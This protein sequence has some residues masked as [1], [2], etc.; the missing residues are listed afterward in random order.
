MLLFML[1]IHPALNK[2]VYTHNLPNYQT[3]NLCNHAGTETRQTTTVTGPQYCRTFSI[4]HV[5][6]VRLDHSVNCHMC[7]TIYVDF[8][9][10]MLITTAF[11]TKHE[12]TANEFCSCIYTRI[13]FVSCLPD[14]RYY[15]H[16]SPMMIIG[17]MIIIAL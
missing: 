8:T 5:H 14:H 4:M 1:D 6:L 13:Y 17:T 9:G 7:K 15:Y 10:T 11:E 12:L 16:H 3:S 2:I